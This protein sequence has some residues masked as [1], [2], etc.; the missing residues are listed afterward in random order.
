MKN[1]AVIFSF[2][3]VIVSFILCFSSYVQGKIADFLDY[4]IDKIGDESIH[5]NRH[6]NFL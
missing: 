4:L 2:V 6:D 5:S 3:F 1:I